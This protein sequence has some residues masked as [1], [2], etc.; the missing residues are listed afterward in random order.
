[1]LLFAVTFPSFCFS[2]SSAITLHQSKPL[3]PLPILPSNLT[4]C[5]PS[6][7][8]M[9]KWWVEELDCSIPNPSLLCFSSLLAT[10]MKA[11]LSMASQRR[12]VTFLPVLRC[13]SN[14]VSQFVTYC[15]FHIRLPT[16]LAGILFVPSYRSIPLHQSLPP[17][18]M[19]ILT[20]WI[21]I[22]PG[23][24]LSVPR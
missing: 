15:W 8:S 16:P 10:C 24:I 2:Y 1:M 12:N 7:P 18:R 11:T 20:P 9:L 21:T 14:T 6:L 19:I 4:V 22:P 3:P 13:G 23:L 17:L 5:L